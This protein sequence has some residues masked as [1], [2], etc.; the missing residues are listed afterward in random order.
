[1]DGGIATAPAEE[2]THSYDL[3]KI[4]YPM[5]IYTKCRWCEGDPECS[6]CN[7]SGGYIPQIDGPGAVFL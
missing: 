4:D 5:G 6:T 1:M 7:G 3:V 2:K